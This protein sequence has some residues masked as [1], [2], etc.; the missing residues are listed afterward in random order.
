M[1][2]PVVWLIVYRDDHV[3]KTDSREKESKGRDRRATKKM[4]EMVAANK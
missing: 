1:F 2:C 4:R 3:R